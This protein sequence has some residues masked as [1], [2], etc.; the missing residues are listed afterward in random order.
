[1]LA[2]LKMWFTAVAPSLWSAI[3]SGFF[4]IVL[5]AVFILVIIKAISSNIAAVL[6]LVTS[7]Q[8]NGF[9]IAIVLSVY[10]ISSAA[11]KILKKD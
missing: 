8:I 5:L 7:F 9:E 1:M 11:V 10:F 3:K 4:K 2:K 6:A